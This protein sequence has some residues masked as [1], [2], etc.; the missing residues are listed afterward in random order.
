[1]T[2]SELIELLIKADHAYHDLNDPIMSDAEYN[3]LALVEYRK[4]TGLKW[5]GQATAGDRTHV[6]LMGTL[7]KV[8]SVHELY[9][10]LGDHLL[11][12]MPKVDGFGLELTYGPM[13]TQPVMILRQALSRGR[14]SGGVSF[15]EVVTAKAKQLSIPGILSTAPTTR[16]VG[17]FDT[18]PKTVRG[19]A[20]LT[21]GAF[22]EA[23][24]LRLADGET[25]FKNRRNAAAGIFAKGD[26]RYLQFLSFVAYQVF[27]PRF[28]HHEDKE[29]DT[30]YEQL[31]WLEEHGFAIP[32]SFHVFANDANPDKLKTW[33]E[34]QD[35]P[36]EVDGVVF[37]IDSM[38]TQ[39][40][41]GYGREFPYFS[42]AFKF[43]DTRKTTILRSI[44]AEAT[45]T[46]RI[47][48]VAEFDPI[49]LE[50]A[51][52]ENATLHNLANLIELGIQPG[53]EITVY[54]SGLIIPQ[55]EAPFVF[56]GDRELHLYLPD[57]CP[58]CAGAVTRNHV[59][60]L[61]ENESCPAKL[62][63][64]IH[65]AFSK[66][67]WD[68]DGVGLAL[69]EA[70]VDSGKVETLA[71]LFTLKYGGVDFWKTSLSDTVRPGAA[72]PKLNTFERGETTLGLTQ[73]SELDV[74]GKKLGLSSAKKFLAGIEA[75][76]SKPWAITL[77]ALGCPGL[78]E[79]ECAQI[80]AAYG[81]KSL[82]TASQQSDLSAVLLQALIGL[83]GIGAKTA[84]DFLFWLRTN[85]DW[86]SEL[87]ESGLRV[88][89]EAPA[90]P[91][92]AQFAGEVVVFT[93]G[94]SKPRTWYEQA[95]VA[96]GGAK[97]GSISKKTTLVVAGT[98]AGS[99]LEAALALG[100][101]VI[102]EFE[103]LQ[104]LQV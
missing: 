103:F 66:K 77:H 95:V 58:S 61:C 63:K 73:L 79:P 75:A 15:G 90:G 47:S 100:I 81:L 65:N 101:K 57:T 99:K 92:S 82:L 50:G 23:N 46:G 19:E 16:D 102:G 22:E 53:D 83:P 72:L 56:N 39:R 12:G 11:V 24:A 25:P 2:F 35:L 26:P 76:K 13:D 8:H 78:G 87:L 44:R 32:P 85:Y 7:D 54:R 31:I 3:H 29:F 59:D 89:A 80:A 10:A 68:V 91:V 6:R 51:T 36:Y 71:D 18:T 60:L 1:M 93:G 88:E 27:D 20:Y 70:L 62:A 94:L 48:L 104:M 69:C 74:G 84:S 14:R 37:S 40:S 96:A 33:L 64:A 43:E 4:H 98:D 49:E 17:A 38:D 9:K 5:H 55:I 67:N 34:D 41:L 97:S 21:H 86:L 42:A 52:I 28:E 45:R 30:H